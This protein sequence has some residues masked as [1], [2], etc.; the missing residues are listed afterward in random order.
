MRFE[1]T[2]WHENKV[3]MD[4]EVGAVLVNFDFSLKNLQKLRKKVDE[5]IA[6]MEKEA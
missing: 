2:D 5:A 6:G 4:F 1:I 3:S